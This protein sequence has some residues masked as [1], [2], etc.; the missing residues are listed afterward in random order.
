VAAVHLVPLLCWSL[1]PSRQARGCTTYSRTPAQSQLWLL[2]FG[3]HSCVANVT[4][5][6]CS[7][8]ARPAIPVQCAMTMDVF[9]GVPKRALNRTARGGTRCHPQICLFTRCSPVCI[10]AAAC[11]WLQLVFA[12]RFSADVHCTGLPLQDEVP[13]GAS[14]SVLLPVPFLRVTGAP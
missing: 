3:I 1:Q 10:A 9:G 8:K 6:T 4:C 5:V 12:P 13:A 11:S 7:R 2:L 14:H